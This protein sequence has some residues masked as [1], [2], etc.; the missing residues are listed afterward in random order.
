MIQKIKSKRIDLPTIYLVENEEDFKELPKGL[1]YIIGK[2][3]ELS[4]ITVFLEF[5]VLYKS[6]LKTGLPIKWMDCL[7]RLGYGGSLREFTLCSGGEFDVSGGSAYTLSIDDFVQDQYIVDFDRLSALKIL[8]VWLDDIRSSIEANIVDEVMFDPLAFNKQ[9]GLNIGAGSVKSSL[10]NLL[11]L[12]VSGS[13]PRGVVV[14]ITNLAKLMSKRFY[15]DVMI[16]SGRT[17]LIDY[18]QVPESNIIKIAEDS[19]GG[20]EG[21][22]Y[23]AIVEEPKEYNTVISF[24]DDDCPVHFNKRD[25]TPLT[26][27]FKIN[28]LYSLHT[29]SCSDN[30]T[31]YAKHFKPKTTIK[32]KDW[33]NTISSK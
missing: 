3:S 12:D 2:A 26:P 28:T 31:G 30:V 21:A 17:V 6:C 22:M 29:N 25:N 1:P 19:G 16:T 32:V 33:V 14:T 7:A 13:I 9:L 4:F 24:G 27:R 8:P 23:K 5:Q 11:I 15:A 18:E 10:K 20:N